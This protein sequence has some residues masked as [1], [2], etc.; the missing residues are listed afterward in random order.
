MLYNAKKTTIQI[1]QKTLERL[2]ELKKYE[3]E[4]YDEI[5][6]FLMGEAE[7]DLTEEEIEEVK[8]SLEEI[9]RKGIKKTTHKIEEVAKELNIKLE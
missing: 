6:N 2:K 9:K 4:S 7:E 1:N 8:L 5:V 3:R